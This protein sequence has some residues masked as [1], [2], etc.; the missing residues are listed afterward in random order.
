MVTAEGESL[1]PV[2][3]VYIGEINRGEIA[4]GG[5]PLTAADVHAL[6]RGEAAA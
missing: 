4:V 1:R 2:T 5:R 3:W 6:Q